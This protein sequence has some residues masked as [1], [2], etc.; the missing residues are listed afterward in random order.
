M[1]VVIFPSMQSDNKLQMNCRNDPLD[2]NRV[3][4]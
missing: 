3:N 1:I 2:F 4:K